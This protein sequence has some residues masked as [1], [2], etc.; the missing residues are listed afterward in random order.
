MRNEPIDSDVDSHLF[1]PC[2]SLISVLKDMDEYK[3]AGWATRVILRIQLGGKIKA[4]SV[5]LD[6]ALKL[7][8]VREDI[9]D[10]ILRTH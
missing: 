3:D 10:S 5:K 6:D 8:M 9:H 2:R 1:P 7:F 4:A